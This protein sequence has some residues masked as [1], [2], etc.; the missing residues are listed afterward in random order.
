MADFMLVI[1]NDWVDVAGPSAIVNGWF[2][3]SDYDWA[4][5]T[6]VYELTKVNYW[7]Y[8]SIMNDRIDATGLSQY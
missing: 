6:G 3:V 5:A 8:V 2:Y 4:E 1:V 7:F